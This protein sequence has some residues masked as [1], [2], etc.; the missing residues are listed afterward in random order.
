MPDEHRQLVVEY[1][2]G[3]DTFSAE[4][5]AILGPLAVFPTQDSRSTAITTN[6]TSW[7]IAVP[8][9]N[10][11]DLLLL[12]L[13]TDGAP[14]INSISAVN[15]V[16][17][18]LNLI[19]TA[20]GTA[21][22][23]YAAWLRAT[24]T[25]A[26]DINV[27]VALS[28]TEQGI[29]RVWAITGAHAS[30]APAV[31][32]VVTG[33]STTPDP[34]NLD[35]AGWATED[36]MWFAVVSTDAAV[37]A[38]GY[39]SNMDTATGFTDVSGGGNGA[40]LHTCRASSAVSALNPNTFSLSASETWVAQTI[41]IRPAPPPVT[42]SQAQYRFRNDD[43]DQATATW[44]QAVNTAAGTIDADSRFRLRIT[45]DETG[46]GSDPAAAT[47]KLQ[48][49]VDAG[50]WQD[51][52]ASATIARPSASPNV[53]DGA[54]TTQQISSGLGT[55][56]AG[57][58]DE[59]DGA[60]ASV[61]LGIGGVTELEW[62]LA[63]YGAGAQ[64]APGD[65]VEFRV[66]TTAGGL[67]NT[68]AQ[69]PTLTVGAVVRRAQV[70]WVEMRVPDVAGP[71]LI[72][73]SLNRPMTLTG[74]VQKKFTKATQAQTL[75]LTP[76]LSRKLFDVK[77]L[78]A[79]LT[80]SLAVAKSFPRLLAQTVTFTA[81]M[82]RVVKFLRALDRSMTLTPVM[83]RLLIAKRAVSASLTLTPVMSRLALRSRLMAAG[84]TLTP[85]MTAFRFNARTLAGDLS[86]GSGSIDTLP[87]LLDDFTYNDNVVNPAHW[88]GDAWG[89][90]NT[91]RQNNATDAATTSPGS[92][93]TGW[94]DDAT[95]LNVDIV[96]EITALPGNDSAIWIEAREIEPGT[97]NHG[98]Y[99]FE[100]YRRSATDEIRVFK[101][102]NNAQFGGAFT[103]LDEDMQVGTLM[104]LR[105]FGS[106]VAVT[107]ETWIKHP[108]GSWTLMGTHDDT[109]AS[110]ITNAGYVGL[111][112]GASAA[113]EVSAF[114]AGEIT[115]G[116]GPQMKM[117]PNFVRGAGITFT[118][119]MSRRLLLGRVMALTVT[120][121]AAMTR[122]RYASRLLTGGITF[123]PTAVG[124]KSRF[125]TIGQNITFTN[126]MTRRLLMVRQMAAGI[127]FTGNMSLFKKFFRAFP[128]TATL[129]AAL[130]RTA[131]RLRTLAVT[132]TFTG[133]VS[134]VKS[135][136][137]TMPVT[138]TLTPT[139][140]RRLSLFKAM[141]ISLL[142]NPSMNAQ[143]VAQTHNRSFPGAINFTAAM[144]RY[145]WAGRTLALTATLTAAMTRRAQRFRTMA[146][147]IT[148]TATMAARAKF[149]RALDTVLSFDPVMMRKHPKNY[150]LNMTFQNEMTW[151]LP[152]KEQT[153]AVAINFTAGFFQKLFRFKEYPVRIGIPIGKLLRAGIPDS[154]LRRGQIK[155]DPPDMK[156]GM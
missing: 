29:V 147:G 15:G 86:F 18:T 92:F 20:N 98:C 38:T 7:S 55:F 134:A 126:T 135:R 121:A 22:K 19:N 75:T 50:S 93:I 56:V 33:T 143:G 59:V 61:D 153:M 37:S 71:N 47:Y 69:S 151:L 91:L 128:V 150:A 52:N 16:S 141:A 24:S 53:A 99:H 82:T 136:F 88:S 145:R 12:V 85:A 23:L 103:D 95:F 74:A 68:Y 48:A 28:A 8:A 2:E 66:V 62:S 73:I 13:G 100:W 51:V 26:T 65:T 44:K 36:T 14:T 49:R 94:W 54:A 79:T 3:R 105:V 133:T 108:G 120:L 70:T 124:V 107:I 80:A 125:F 40:G 117:I 142:M 32:T 30:T 83:S 127:T 154:I 152:S 115:A 64:I 144:T 72:P 89:G 6:S 57:S 25:Q 112:I 139:M 58:F 148:F 110:R 43:G 78:G 119:V 41:A 106:G 60:V 27:T 116:G 109:E 97:G 149:F 45:V 39:P 34:P 5:R 84:A 35:P 123:T 114:Y 101:V 81:T 131:K 104:R 77:T 146:A 111:G 10:S 156:G 1:A 21:N 90:V 96:A 132:A 11:G 31:G 42:L 63:L 137:F 129:A 9:H 46:G 17:W 87:P 122:V 155:D 113:A 4:E 67:L 118:P 102:I 130:T 138:I 140:T 76:A